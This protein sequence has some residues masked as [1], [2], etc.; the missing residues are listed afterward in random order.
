MSV[1]GMR[2]F[3]NDV[4]M[5]GIQTAVNQPEMLTVFKSV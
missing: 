1:L 4:K 2:M 3:E 5:Y